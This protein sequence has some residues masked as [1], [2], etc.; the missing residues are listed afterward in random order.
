MGRQVR[1]SPVFHGIEVSDP[2]PGARQQANNRLCAANARF[3]CARIA[4]ER[5]RSLNAI[6]CGDVRERALSSNEP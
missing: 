3:A 5:A 2:R 6:Y 1:L 4:G